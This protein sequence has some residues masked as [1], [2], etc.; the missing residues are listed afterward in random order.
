[1]SLDSLAAVWAVKA[2][3]ANA[4]LPP[5]RLPLP[6]WPLQHSSHVLTD[7]HRYPSMLIAVFWLS[8]KGAWTTALVPDDQ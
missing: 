5:P 3:A 4:A 6:E 2:F 7:D 8:L 1:M